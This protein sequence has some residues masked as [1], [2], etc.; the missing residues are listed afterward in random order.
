MSSSFLT[1]RIQIFVFLGIFFLSGCGH[2]KPHEISSVVESDQQNR[3]SVSRVVEPKLLN[4]DPSNLII[5]PPTAGVGV[6]AN[7]SL[8]RISLTLVKSIT[9]AID[10]S[11]SSIKVL[12]SEDAEQSNLIL[13][14]HV[15]YWGKIRK[16]KFLILSQWTVSLAVEIKVF[17]RES[18]K[19]VLIFNEEKSSLMNKNMDDLGLELAQEIGEDVVRFMMTK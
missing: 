4:R 5:I 14:G 16:S 11:G 6:Q 18:G 9:N 13:R 8:E 19:L 10:Q 3:S 12:A 17:D 1:S 2:I 7:Q 15:M